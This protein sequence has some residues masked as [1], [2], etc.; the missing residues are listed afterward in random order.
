[1]KNKKKKSRRN[2][3]KIELKLIIQNTFISFDLSQVRSSQ[4]PF[5]FLPKTNWI[6]N[7]LYDTFN[8]LKVHL[9]SIA[10]QN[11]RTNGVRLLTPLLVLPSRKRWFLNPVYSTFITNN[12]RKW[13]F[14][15]K[16]V[17]TG[18]FIHKVREFF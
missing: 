18:K 8:S 11:F 7:L 2:K 5:L 12:S 1:M 14:E 4:L 13:D 15:Y 6:N 10:L 17:A 3:S 9:T 16:L